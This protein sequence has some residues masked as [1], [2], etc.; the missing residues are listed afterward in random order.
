MPV[1]TT[2][3]PAEKAVLS[4]ALPTPLSSA[5]IR[6]RL[7]QLVQL[8]VQPLPHRARHRHQSLTPPSDRLLRLLERCIRRRH[9]RRRHRRR[10]RRHRR[11]RRRRPAHS[12]AV[13]WMPKR[14]GEGPARSGQSTA[15]SWTCRQHG[16]PGARSARPSA[17]SG[18]LCR[19]AASCY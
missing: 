11:R 5:T 6:L 4:V 18:R 17:P 9:R 2:K 13:R 19:R 8:P 1:G 12:W 7:T 15:G 10:R 14:S 3:L 16:A